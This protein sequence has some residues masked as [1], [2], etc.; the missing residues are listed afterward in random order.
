MNMVY[1]SPFVFFFK[2]MWC[3]MWDLSSLTRKTKIKP[4][5]PMLGAQS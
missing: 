3:D 4:V 2:V 5:P 1:F